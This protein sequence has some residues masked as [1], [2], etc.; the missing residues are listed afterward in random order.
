MIFLL[1]RTAVRTIVWAAGIV[2][3]ALNDF[4][5]GIWIVFFMEA[6]QVRQLQAALAQAREVVS[7]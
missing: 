5:N 3:L 2:L 6:V 4:L 7:E 1:L